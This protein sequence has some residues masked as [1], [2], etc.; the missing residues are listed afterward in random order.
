MPFSVEYWLYNAWRSNLKNSIFFVDFFQKCF[1][2][3][4]FKKFFGVKSLNLENVQV[5]ESLIKIELPRREDDL[6]IPFWI[7]NSF[8]LK[9]ILIS[10]TQKYRLPRYFYQNW[11]KMAKNMNAFEWY[12]IK[13]GLFRIYSERLFRYFDF[14]RVWFRSAGDGIR[15]FTSLYTYDI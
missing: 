15:F 14:F 3:I 6:M 13:I 4:F 7:W 8:E 11:L 10:H 1:L 5:C 12:R 9:M 2:M